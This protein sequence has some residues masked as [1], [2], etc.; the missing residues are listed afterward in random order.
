MGLFS[1]IAQGIKKTKDSFLGGLQK[2]FNS[3][4]KIDEEL[5]EQLEEQMILSD[6][7]VDTSVEIC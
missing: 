3:F 1:K 6:I 4:T 7:G 5:F 2:V